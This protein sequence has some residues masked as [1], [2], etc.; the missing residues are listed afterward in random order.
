MKLIHLEQRTQAWH[1]WRAGKDIGGIARITA[2]MI[3]AIMCVSP[4]QTPHDLWQE[5][6]GRKP[7][8]EMN[9]AMSEGVRKEPI[10]REILCRATD[11]EFVDVCVEHDT[12]PWA[13]ASLDGISPLCDRIAEIKCPGERTHALAVA[14]T[15]PDY[16]W[17][18]I[19]WQLFVTGIDE[20]IYLSFR[21]ETVNDTDQAVMLTVKADPQRQAELFDAALRFRQYLIDD[22]PPAGEE[23]VQAA[24]IH[25]RLVA[26]AEEIKG[27]LDD[28]EKRLRGLL[29]AKGEKRLDGAGLSITKY[30]AKGSVD[31]EALL[32]HFHVTPTQDDIEKF[33]APP[34]DRYKITVSKKEPIPTPAE[35]AGLPPTSGLSSLAGLDSLAA[36][37]LSDDGFAVSLAAVAW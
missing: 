32:K 33:R 15:V 36:M 35:A 10:A 29:D 5:L 1:D 7:P 26:Q 20:C 4:L 17:D 22:V 31:W 2:S 19:Q 8:K 9:F 3:A 34:A 18:Q 12:Y 25:R 23:F 24:T 14:G 13:A 28:S 11:T 21:G 30:P 27:M 37:P 6:T 16:Y